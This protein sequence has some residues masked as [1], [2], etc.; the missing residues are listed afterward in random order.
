MTATPHPELPDGPLTGLKVLDLSRVLAAPTATQVLGDMGADVVKIER[1]GSGDDTRGWGPPFLKDKDGIE[2]RESAYFMSANRNKR[3]VALDLAS[4]EGVAAVKRLAAQAD[5]VVENFKVGDLARRGLGYDD[6]SAINPRLI[7]CSVTGFG[8]TGPYAHRAGYDFLVQGMGGLMSVTGTPEGEPMKVGVGI[9]DVMTGM[10]ALAA[11]LAALRARDVTGQGQYIDM[12]LLDTQISWL[13][14][15][16]QAYLIDGQAPERLGNA[17]PTIVPY[18]T[19]PASDGWFI[20]AVGNDGQFARFCEAAGRPELAANP[21][22]TTNRARVVNRAVLVPLL[23][24]I[25]QT[26]PA[27]DWMAALEAV[28]VP[29]G[30][31]NTVAQAFA[32]PHA[33]GRGARITMPH[34][35]AAGGT[36]DLAGSPIH[37]HGTPVSYRRPPPMLGQHSVEVLREAGFSDD[38]IAALVPDAGA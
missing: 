14:N 34:P 35:A 18:E 25:T 8:Q 19:F 26:R 20:L 27:A 5:V 7:Y 12:A 3:S 24:E 17:H 11:I 23:R 38:E 37:M 1:P 16:G 30:P 4:P 21:D 29:C 36:V 32:D 2:T 10:Y 9:A 28:G 15:V 13:V 31:V 22:Y 33:A 6:L